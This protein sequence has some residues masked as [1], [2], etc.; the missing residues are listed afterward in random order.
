MRILIA[1]EF[2]GIVRETF[3]LKGCDA[4]SCD[5]I[6]TKIPGQHI[7]DNVLK[8]LNDGWDM[9]I[10]HPP[11]TYLS[12]VGARWLYPGSR[13]N[14]ERYKKG[15]EAKEFFLKLYNSDI[16]KICIENPV[17]FRV[18][19]LPSYKQII[20][21]YQHGHNQSKQTCLWLKN[22]PKLKPSNIVKVEQNCRGAKG[23]WYNKG[24]RN[25]SQNRAKTFIGIAQA[26]AEQWSIKEIR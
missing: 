11:C 25:R 24:G 7:K 12:R 5:L 10:A 19:K 6:D 4:W 21:P 13:L 22:L 15:L 1:C 20:Q 2:S 16:E 26:M 3:R 18:F 23:S 8:H 14:A 17:P 9:M